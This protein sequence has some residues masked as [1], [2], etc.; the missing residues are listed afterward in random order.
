MILSKKEAK[1]LKNVL[2]NSKGLDIEIALSIL[3]RKRTE[4][5]KLKISDITAALDE[6]SQVDMKNKNDENTKS[7]IA[8]K[9]VTQRH[10]KRIDELV[11]HENFE[12]DF[13]KLSLSFEK[14]L[15]KHS[16]ALK[17]I[18]VPVAPRYYEILSGK[19]QAV[20]NVEVNNR[21]QAG[22]VP[23]GGV[24][25]AAFGM[26]PVAGNQYIQAMVKY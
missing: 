15:E 13:E 10:A 7:R 19:T 25:A 14:I 12:K 20:L 2:G 17:Q 16:N 22:W 6:L 24:G 1:Y 26:S 4:S 18:L 23:I 8:T 5:N 11:E 3:N 21:M 9:S